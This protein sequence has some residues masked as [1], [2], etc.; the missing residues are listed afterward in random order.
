MPFDFPILTHNFGLRYTVGTMSYQLQPPTPGVTQCL[1]Q[2][3]LSVTQAVSKPSPSAT[4]DTSGSRL[5]VGASTSSKPE[6]DNLYRV[7]LIGVGPPQPKQA[8]SW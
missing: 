1:N 5:Y 8:P 7:P 6:P 3:S 4:A 2:S